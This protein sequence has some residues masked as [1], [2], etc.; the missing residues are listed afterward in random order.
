MNYRLPPS[1]LFLLLVAFTGNLWA[2]D[3]LV[4][5]YTSPDGKTLPYRLLIP[6][7][8]DAKQKYPVVL[9]FHGAGERGNDNVA[10]LKYGPP[11][12]DTLENRSKYPCFVI[13]PQCPADQK[14]VD[15]DWGAP[16]GIRPPQPSGP[17]QLALKCLDEITA[18]YSTDPARTYVMGLSMGGYATWDCVTRFPERFAAGIPICGGGDDSTVTAAVAKVPV[19]AFHSSDDPTVPVVRTRH[20]IEAMKKAGGNPH[21]NE[22]QGL[23]HFCWPKAYAE[24]NLLPW[25]FARRLGVPDKS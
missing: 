9:F 2:E 6:E 1:F 4:K 22:Y 24:P 15:M 25:L 18:A 10:Q 16:T 14:W 3:F 20:M 13:A 23:G 19:W 21:Y 12:F 8:Y 7:N 5:T 11:L 17:M